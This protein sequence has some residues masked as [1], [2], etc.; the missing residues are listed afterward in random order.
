MEK[1]ARVQLEWRDF[2]DCS[3]AALYDMLRFRQAIFIV[4]QASPFADLDG[5]DHHAHHLLLRIDGALTGY[6]RVILAAAARRVAIGRVAVAERWRRRGLARTIMQEALARCRRDYP[7]LPVALSAQTYL[8]PFYRS[9]GFHAVSG[10][11]LDYG[12]EHVEMER[13]P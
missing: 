7:G 6:A 2:G 12:I 5:H 10:P 3:A 1:V 9:L 13:R 11:A 4:E 8:L